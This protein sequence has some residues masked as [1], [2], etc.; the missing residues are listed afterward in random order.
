[1]PFAAYD[2][3]GSPQEFCCIQRD[4]LWKLHWLKGGKWKRIQTGLPDDATECGP[5]AEFEDGMWKLSFQ[6]LLNF[7]PKLSTDAYVDKSK[8]S[9]PLSAWG[10]SYVTTG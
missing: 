7:L 10:E 8:Q 2:G 3:N 4:G 9:C 1:M 5:T 6:R